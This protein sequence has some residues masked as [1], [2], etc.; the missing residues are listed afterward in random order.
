MAGRTA[1][2]GVLMLA[3]QFVGAARDRQCCRYAASAPSDGGAPGGGGPCAG[4]LDSCVVR[5]GEG[6]LSSPDLHHCRVLSDSKKDSGGRREDK[7]SCLA[8]A[9]DEGTVDWPDEG[10]PFV[11]KPYAFADGASARPMPA[12]E[13][14]LDYDQSWSVVRFRLA[15][16]DLCAEGGEE[17]PGQSC[18]PRCVEILKNHEPPPGEAGGRVAYDCEVGFYVSPA[19]QS[20]KV[21]AGDTYELSL[22]LSGVRGGDVGDVSLACRSFYFLMP[23]LG[24]G[25]AGPAL[26]G[27]P[28]LDKQAIEED[29]TVV[30]HFPGS[31]LARGP[32]GKADQEVIL[33]SRSD[34]ADEWRSLGNKSLP[35]TDSYSTLKFGEADFDLENGHYR[36]ALKGVADPVFGEA[37]VVANFEI[38]T[39]GGGGGAAA[40]L[41]LLL[42]LV[43]AAAGALYAYRRRERV[44]AD[45]VVHPNRLVESGRVAGKSVFVVTNVDNRHHIDVVMALNRYLKAHCAVSEVYFALDPNTGIESHHQQDPWKWAQVLV[46]LRGKEEGIRVDNLI[47][48]GRRTSLIAWGPPRTP[49]WR[50]WQ[51]P[52]H[53]WGCPSTRTCRSTRPSSQLNTLKT[54]QVILKP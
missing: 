14:L 42:V 4:G 43:A 1:F 13:V 44:R 21:T 52:L 3:L 7:T 23:G 28:L 37:V 27:L 33:Y 17:P 47:L 6:S 5:D 53:P 38:T 40:A 22:C 11:L 46:F 10:P 20:V 19:D 49:W 39:E 29:Q 32:A 26:A 41:V 15:N 12:V 9:Y 31:F 24:E 45:S 25:D 34:P 54:W 2:L 18:N 51:L 36:V 35:L 30:L 50:S 48:S 16:R 8:E